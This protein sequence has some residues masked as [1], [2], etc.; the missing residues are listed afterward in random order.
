MGDLL[1]GQPWTFLP[2]SSRLYFRHSQLPEGETFRTKTQ[3]SPS[4][5]RVGGPD[6]RRFRR[7]LRDG[8]RSEALS[9]TAAGATTDRDCDSPAGG[10]AVVSPPGCQ[11]AGRWEKAHRP[12]PKM[13]A[14]DGC[15]AT[16]REVGRSVAHR[17][18][19]GLWPDAQDPLQGSTLP[20][21]RQW[22]QRTGARFRLYGRRVR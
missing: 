6:S 15:S 17:T 14:T 16:S 4:G 13:G 10:C 19:V 5:W 2:H 22:V 12:S 18:S 1:P 8:N 11:P 21:G 9:A 3:C 7:C 20:V